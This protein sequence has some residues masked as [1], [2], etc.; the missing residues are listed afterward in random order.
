MAIITFTDILVFVLGCAF[1]A[2]WMLL[3][4]RGKK[5][6]WMFGDQLNDEDYPVKDLYCIGY[7][8]VQ[9][10]NLD[11]KS[12]KDRQLRK[13]FAVLY[14]EKFADYYIRVAYSQQIAMALTVLTLAAPVYFVGECNLLLFVAVI[15]GAG[16]TYYYYATTTKDK[17]RKRSDELLAE[18]SDVVS[19]LAL[20]V[21][22]GMIL[23]EAWEDTAYSKN[24]TIYQ[25]MRRS[26][27]DMQNG[28]AEVDA[29]FA[30][31]Q[32]CMLPEIKKFS[33]TLIQGLMKGSGDLASMLTQQS[34]EVWEMKKQNVHRQGELANNKLLMPMCITFIGILIMVMVPIFTNLGA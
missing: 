28:K 4:L 7:A 1:I 16:A 26:V 5:D 6:D 8:V 18:F 32:S 14:G 20:L 31:G 11:F 12:K 13:E 25:E 19:K 33:S 2:V 17:I 22:S 15:A 29:L 23:K 3:L 27:V 10:L 34:K 21:N 9:M 30:F 24:G